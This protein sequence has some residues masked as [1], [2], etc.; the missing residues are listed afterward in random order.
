MLPGGNLYVCNHI[1]SFENSKMSTTLQ[2]E[3]QTNDTCNNMDGPQNNDP[4]KKVTQ[5]RRT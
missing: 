4:L 3:E 1:R 2:N 5:K